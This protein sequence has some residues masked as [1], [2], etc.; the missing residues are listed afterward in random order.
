MRTRLYNESQPYLNLQVASRRPK[1]CPLQSRSPSLLMV[2]CSGLLG[3]WNGKPEDSRD[4][5]RGVSR[6]FHT[7]YSLQAPESKYEV[8]TFGGKAPRTHSAGSR[9]CSG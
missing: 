1:Q 2:G 6:Q 7:W 3:G 4:S 9:D 8:L 5:T